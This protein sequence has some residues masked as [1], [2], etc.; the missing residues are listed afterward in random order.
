MLKKTRNNFFN[1]YDLT[2]LTKYLSQTIDDF[3]DYFNP[4]KELSNFNLKNL[5]I[6]VF[7]LVEKQLNKM[8]LF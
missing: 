1:G 7:D 5:F 8:K 4:N 6:N 3:R 2:T